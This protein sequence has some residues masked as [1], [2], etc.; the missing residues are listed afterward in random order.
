MIL[1]SCQGVGEPGDGSSSPILFS[2][3]LTGEAGNNNYEYIELYNHAEN[4]VDLNGYSLWYRLPSSE[5][6][7]RVI[8]WSVETLI[9]A[10]G[11]YLLALDGQDVGIVPNAT[12]KQS[13]NTTGGG[14]L[15]RDERGE[16]VDSVGWGQAPDLFFEGSPIPAPE[17]GIALERLPGGEDGNERDKDDNASD[18]KHS[19]QPNPQNTGSLPTPIGQRS[20]TI[21]LQGPATVEPGS[22]FKYSLIL[23][24]RSDRTIE[25]ISVQL[26]LPPE[27]LIREVPAAIRQEGQ[28][29][30]WEIASLQSGLE[31]SQSIL[32]E[33]PWVYL[34][35]L[36]DKTYAQI[37]EEN[38]LNFANPILTKI[39]GGIIP[40]GT[41]RG[42][43]GAELTIEGIA[44]MYTGGYFTGS[45]NVKFYLQDESG[46]LQVQVFGGLGEVSIPIGAHIRVRG[47]VSV[48][49]GS[50]QIVPN[51]V[52]DDV[53]I[54]EQPYEGPST[55]KKVSIRQAA[56]DRETLPGRLIAVEGSV[57]R[58]RELTYGFEI[59]L[60]DELGQTL[61]L[62]IDKLTEMSV[63]TIERGHIKFST[64]I[65]EV[66]DGN[67]TLNPR[68]PSDLQEVFP[69]ILRVE[70]LAPNTVLPG[71]TISVSLI[72]TNYSSTPLQDVEIG[73]RVPT[74]LVTIDSISE[75]GS[76][77]GDQLTW[78]IS[79]IGA[80]G[81]RASVTFQLS[82]LGEDGHIPIEIQADIPGELIDVDELKPWRIFI[83]TSVPIWAIQ[84]S[85]FGS[86]Y[87][88]D[89]VTSSSIITANFPDL[90]GFWIQT[91]EG[92][93]SSQTS[94][95]LFI[96][97]D[98]YIV[99]FISG[100]YVIVS[101]KVREISQQTMIEVLRPD[102]IQL[103]EQG[104]PIPAAI[105]LD[106]PSDDEDALVYYEALEGM[107]VQ[108]S[109]PAVAVSPTTKFGEYALVLLEYGID[110]IWQGRE[111]GRVI[112]V[113]DGTMDVHYDDST[114]EY[115]V[116]TGDQL[117]GL[118]GP[119]AFT[120]G[121]Y[122]IEPLQPPQIMP[123]LQTFD[124]LP[125]I[126]N[127]AFNVM[128]WNVENLFDI[129]APHPS[130]PPLPRKAEYELALTKVANTIY[131]A[132]APILVGLQEVENIGILED[133]AQHTQLREFGYLP[134]LIEG[135]DGRGIDVGYLVRGDRATIIDVPQFVAPDGLTSRPPRRMIPPPSTNQIMIP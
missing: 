120:F 86:P 39:E 66:R 114:L 112:K 24:N 96:F 125:L 130:S 131:A 106:P 48:Y 118:R 58:V 1:A 127:E 135:S 95:G 72:A 90:G 80:D 49:R 41:A 73:A 37:G 93:G 36:L 21:R 109:Q 20:L 116:R 108:V 54:L 13:L 76:L 104:R 121:R 27:L 83:G 64:G 119:L 67:V 103:L 74:D 38:E 22:T 7:L 77:I 25:N 18:F 100:D 124:E 17:N 128:T 52:P 126:E 57:I 33:A 31:L 35:F 10:H 79:E 98:D 15:L 5:N 97:T 129:L 53:E 42:L 78:T 46:G 69:P 75:G 3:V 44:T 47:V 9:P 92:D 63:E 91:P 102:A 132:G 89:E 51:S 40:I 32:V 133:L 19:S 34:D 4:T 110:R 62:Y 12:F 26:I 23:A 50:L 134:V 61:R 111:A 117:T 60:E 55:E 123:S 8:Q 70:L 65:L 101:G 87:V 56:N 28:N 107:L 43:I 29:L 6:D 45:G 105:E 85:G 30:Y 2:E 113:D 11:H 59:D 84:G 16:S 71:E 14:L 115:V 81:A 68:R 122:K 94:D 82:V 88:L 99:P